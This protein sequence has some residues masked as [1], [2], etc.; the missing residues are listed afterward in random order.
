MRLKSIFENVRELQAR[1][2]LEYN[3]DQLWISE[4][5]K[6][7]RIDNIRVKPEDR[8]QGIGS[9]V[10]DAVKK[11]AA[12]AGKRVILSAEPDSGKKSAL[13]R[14]YKRHDFKKPGR[15]RD[16]SIPSHTHIWDPRP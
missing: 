13:S 14:F 1:L 10:V 6:Y 7:I 3:L 8:N 5:P 15:N 11:Y 16:F 4:G 2:E 12:D 9:E